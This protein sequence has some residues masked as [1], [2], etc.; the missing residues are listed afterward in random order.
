MTHAKKSVGKKLIF[1]FCISIVLILCLAVSATGIYVYTAF[2][3]T[4][5]MELFQL[6]ANQIPPSFYFYRFEDRVNRVGEAE[7][8][9]T[10]VVDLVCGPDSYLDLPN[11]ISSVEAGKIHS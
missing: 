6:S 4:A 5:P 11:L 2:E 3:R 9:Q 8:L 1:I 10:G 7:L